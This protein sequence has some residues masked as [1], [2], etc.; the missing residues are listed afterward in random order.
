MPTV[1][2][3]EVA[4]AVRLIAEVRS[5]A[6]CPSEAAAH[7]ASGLCRLT[8]SL[9]G[10]IG[11]RRAQGGVGSVEWVSLAACGLDSALT[12]SRLAPLISHPQIVFP[13]TDLLLSDPLPV[14]SASVSS[15]PPIRLRG[16]QSE[17]HRAFSEA[18]GGGD[19]LMSK[20][21]HWVIRG[22]VGWMWFARERGD[23][24]F[25]ARDVMLVDLVAQQINGWF[26]P[27]V[28]RPLVDTASFG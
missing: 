19:R 24:S 28:R 1:R 11:R 26:W 16:V 21:A 7:L 8:H 4:Q 25:T 13:N 10:C 9:R 5:L 20:S 15:Q 2:A 6:H 23:G 22:G 18:L 12:M 27:A 3:H 14:A 17:L